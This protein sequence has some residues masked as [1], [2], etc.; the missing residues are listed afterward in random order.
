M[1]SGIF[2]PLHIAVLV[3]IALIVFGPAKLPDLAKSIGGGIRELKGSINGDDDHD[4]DH[5][6][7]PAV[8]AGPVAPA[9]PV[10]PTVE[11]REPVQSAA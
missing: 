4:R 7:R 2:N 10:A 9:A 8:T 6:E 11:T 5:I 3:G 1:V